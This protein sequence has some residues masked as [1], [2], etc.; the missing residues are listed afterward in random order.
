MNDLVYYVAGFLFLFML[1][2]IICFC[3]YVRSNTLEKLCRNPPYRPHSVAA[4]LR[5][6]Q[7]TGN[8]GN[9]EASEDS[10]RQANVFTIHDETSRESRY[11]DIFF[12]EPN[13]VEAA[14]IRAQLEK[15]DK[16]LPS[17]EEVMRMTS[18]NP[19]TTTSAVA[20]MTASNASVNTT[21]TILSVPPYSEVDPMTSASSSGNATSTAGGTGSSATTTASTRTSQPPPMPAAMVSSSVDITQQSSSI[22]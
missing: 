6:W 16:D 4:L 19:T 3:C 15:D 17:Y 18:I 14:R 8:G 21:E 2:P 12:I 1:M 13:S 9:S 11:N 20:G 5:A 10:D 7:C 22:V